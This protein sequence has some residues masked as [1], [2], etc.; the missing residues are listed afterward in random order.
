MTKRN[1]LPPVSS[2]YA[3]E[4]K[5]AGGKTKIQ[6]SQNEKGNLRFSEKD[7]IFELSSKLRL[8]NFS[9]FA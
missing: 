1:L 6:P 8:P 7:S 5:Q 2:I 9:G 3:N 4:W